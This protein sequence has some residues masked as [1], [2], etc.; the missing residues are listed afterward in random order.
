M[1][2]EIENNQT[3]A[4][5]ADVHSA[6]V[7]RLHELLRVTFDSIFTV[8]ETRSLLDGARRL[9]PALIIVDL[10]FSEQGMPH[11]LH[12]LKADV[13]ESRTIVLSHCDDP[14]VAQATMAEGAD[15]V[16]LKSLIADDL[17]PAVDAILAGGRFASACFQ[18][19]KADYFNP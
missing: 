9:T 14:A 6:Y 5:L 4:I 15:G 19:D 18:A 8:A 2:F 10:G 7:D 12:T 17:L 3:C 13:P 16:V 11:L 1:A